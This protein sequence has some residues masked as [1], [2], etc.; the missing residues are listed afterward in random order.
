MKTRVGSRAYMVT[1]IEG[2]WEGFE[3]DLKKFEK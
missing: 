1:A 2:I 3:R